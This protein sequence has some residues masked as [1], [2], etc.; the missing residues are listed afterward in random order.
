MSK[1]YDLSAPLWV[2]KDY[3]DLTSLSRMSEFQQHF[4]VPILIFSGKTDMNE[5]S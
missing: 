3:K 4:S 1:S 5:L 2:S